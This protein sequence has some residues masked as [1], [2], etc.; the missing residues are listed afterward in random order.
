[1]SKAVVPIP[2]IAVEDPCT[3]LGRPE[4]FGVN[5]G[6]IVYSYQQISAQGNWPST[7]STIT[8]VAPPPS[9]DIIVDRRVYL[10]VQWQVQPSGVYG[11]PGSPPPFA[12]GYDAPRA[13]PSMQALQSVS[14]VVNNNTI[15]QQYDPIIALMQYNLGR[16]LQEYD[17]SGAPD[18]MDQYPDYGTALKSA[19]HPLVDSSYN[20]YQLPRGGFPV[21]YTDNALNA[22]GTSYGP[23]QT[24][25]PTASFYTIEPFFMTPF[26][27]YGE[28]PGFFGVQTLNISLQFTPT[29][30]Q[31]VWSHAYGGNFNSIVGAGG[32][33]WNSVAVSVASTPQLLFR[34]ITP[35]PIKV[36][37]SVMEY[38]YSQLNIYLTAA[39]PSAGTPPPVFTNGVSPVPTSQAGNPVQ[40]NS[41]QFNTIPDQIF[42]YLARNL[43][44]RD[45]STSDTFGVIYQVN[46]NFMN[47][48]GTYYSLVGSASVKGSTRP[49][50]G[51]GPGSNPGHS[52]LF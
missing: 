43:A 32:A 24:H 15:T 30:L 16:D 7:P 2:V 9:P 19:R 37:P 35:S 28:C 26:E 33:Y 17:Y 29:S 4:A 25:V 11:G 5:Q 34:Y 52:M 8:F 3:R 20:P 42:V 31:R 40:C 10:M 23:G 50:Q 46:V 48:T 36:M 27:Q 22:Q 47:Q 45:F 49:I 21:V 14:A 18:Y 44:D 13:F 6:G 39:S 38:Q 41:I 1:M 12:P 51:R